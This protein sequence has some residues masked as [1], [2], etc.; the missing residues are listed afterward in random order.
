MQR[1]GGLAR[2]PIYFMPFSRKTTTDASVI[3]RM[4]AMYQE[5][6]ANGGI[7]LVQPEHILS[8]KLMGLERLASGQNTMAARL[9]ETQAWLDEHCHD[10]L[11]ESDEILDVKFQLIYTLGTQRS[12][13]G[14]PDRWVIMQGIF[15]LVQHHARLMQSLYPRRIEVSKQANASF[16]AIRLL[17]A[18]VRRLLISSVLEDI[19]NSKLPGLVMSNL[20]AR[21]KK[22]ATALIAEYDILEEECTIVQSY[23]AE[24]ENYLKKLL[25]LRGLIS[26]GIL[27]HVLH[28]KRWSVTY[29]LHPSRCLCAVPYRAKGVP[30]PTAE[31][32]HPDVMIALTCLSYYYTG[33]TD[34]QL[35]SCLEI[36]QK[37]DDP[38]FEYET[39]VKADQTFPQKLQHWNAVNLED[40]QQCD[41]HLFPA[42]RYNKKAAD[43]FLT[44]VV[45][46]KEGKEF[47]QKLSTSGWDI[48]A[49]PGSKKVT[50]GFSGTNDNRFLLPSLISQDDL[51]ELQHTSAKVLEILSRHENISYYCAKD[52]KGAQ[53]SSEGLLGFI[54]HVDPNVR[55]L[56]D[57]GAQILDLGNDQVVARWLSIFPDADAGVYFDEDDYAM[58]LT[59]A[60]KRERL[61]NSSFS[62]RMD[63]CIVYLDDVHTRGM[64]RTTLLIPGCRRR[65]Q[66]THTFT[67]YCHIAESADRSRYRSQIAPY[68]SCSSHSGSKARQRSIG[69]G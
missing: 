55:V 16:P 39:W 6:M 23:C 18:K 5:C 54:R 19:C 28:A 67:F 34:N 15:D 29:G 10:V 8:F 2:R 37:V 13:D 4:K 65:A 59:R 12:M 61:S 52:E 22:A 40:R 63:R 68:S 11:D 51:P 46:P 47:D 38:S 60:G 44:N 33:L 57:V 49:R 35:R 26:G 64:F 32:G 62:K 27:M 56:I 43:F 14:Q 66:R 21:V 42:L 3:T 24:D 50:T 41:D 58:V 30:A 9:L 45:F 53:L 48:P 69:S 1:L 20:P 17:S 36:V 7:L 31:F 25:L